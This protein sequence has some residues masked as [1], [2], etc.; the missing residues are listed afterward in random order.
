MIIT[1]LLH[2]LFYFIFIRFPAMLRQ[3]R[4]PWEQVTVISISLMKM[5]NYRKNKSNYILKVNY[6]QKDS[7][8][9]SGEL[10]IYF[11]NFYVV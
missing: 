2:P 8:A 3:V 9:N 11:I 10:F 1:D 6:S 4:R 7:F 5:I